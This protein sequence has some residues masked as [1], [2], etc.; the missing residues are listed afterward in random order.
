MY[1]KLKQE[2]RTL[3]FIDL[4]FSQVYVYKSD[5]PSKNHDLFLNSQ[6]VPIM[7]PKMKHKLSDMAVRLNATENIILSKIFL[8]DDNFKIIQQ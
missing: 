5:F 4:Y 6:S 2:F 7:V 1:I 8:K 3:E